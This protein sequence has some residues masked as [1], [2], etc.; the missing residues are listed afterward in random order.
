ML[1]CLAL[2]CS[3]S[4]LISIHSDKITVTKRQILYPN[5]CVGEGFWGDFAWL[6][7]HIP[8]PTLT[9]WPATV[10]VLSLITSWGF[11]GHSEFDAQ[12][13]AKGVML[14][15]PPYLEAAESYSYSLAC[16]AECTFR[17]F[18]HLLL[19]FFFFW[20]ECF[21]RVKENSYIS[22]KWG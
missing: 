12:L 7:P 22:S 1:K 14:N 17:D 5:R 8:F 3:S 20:R 21:L 19:L 15:E 9:L 11:L 13:A 16:P 18:L 4:Q 6:K 2:N 10:S